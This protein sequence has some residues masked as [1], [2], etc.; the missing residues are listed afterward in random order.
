MSTLQE[1][2]K[3][4]LTQLKDK[5]LTNKERLA[6]PVQDMPCQEAKERSHNMS[7][8]ALG[9]SA[10][11]AMLEA[12]RCLQCKNAP[13]IAGCPVGIDI[14][15]FIKAIED[16]DF[17]KGVAIIKE[18]NMLPAI[19][20]RVC[21]QETQCMERC[22]VGKSL[23]DVE[24]A[25]MIGRLERFVADYE[26]AQG[27]VKTPAVAANTGK[28]VALVGSG[29]AALAAA[30]DLIKAGHTVEVFEAF[31]KLGGVTMYGIPEFRLPK[32]IV[33]AEIAGLKKMGVVFHTDFLVGRTRT[34]HQ[35][36]KDDGFDAVFVASGAGLPVFM[37]IPGENFIGVLSANEYL[38]RSNLMK[39]YHNESS[40]PIPRKKRV[41]VLGGGNVA[42][43][44]ARTALRLGAEE[45]HIVYRRTAEEMPARLEEIHHA[46]EEGVI[47]DYLTQPIEVLGNDKSEV[48]GLKCLRCELGEPDSSGRRRPIA[49]AGSEFIMDVDLVIVAIGNSSNPLIRM[50]TPGLECNKWG[51]I[52]T[53]DDGKTSL[54]GVYAGGDIVLG[55]ATVILAMG[56]GRTAAA[57]ISNY[58]K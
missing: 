10:E 16:G 50:T 18:T 34:I 45:V 17:S 28:R 42:M 9:Y 29:P 7:E 15:G 47:F 46:A 24:K 48:A 53:N 27:E 8:V 35:L 25:V 20:G 51:N 58:L 55:A 19:C 1:Q 3:T 38:T 11:Q 30:G 5:E 32:T 4:L 52:V 13:C 40:T 57:S 43:D 44:A 56:Q 26:A 36:I 39:A 33:E 2:A 37:N 12:R 14:P 41:A 31:Q 23:K 54:D 6:I 21:P 22:T 49:I